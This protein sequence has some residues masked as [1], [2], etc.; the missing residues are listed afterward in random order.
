[1]IVVSG[2]AF[3]QFGEGHVRISYAASH[4]DINRAFEIINE[5]L[6]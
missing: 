1:V 2:S 4:E 6:A 5:L 3:G